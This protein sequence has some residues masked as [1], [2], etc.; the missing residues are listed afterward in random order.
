MKPYIPIA[1]LT[2]LCQFSFAQARP[3]DGF[4][5]LFNG[6][7]LTGWKIPAGD[8][9]HWKVLDGVID[10][11][12]GSEAKGDKNLW[13][14]KSY[15]DFILR[16]D[17]RIKQTTGMYAM[18]DV[19]PDGTYRKDAKGK[20]IKTL[21]PNADSGIYLRGNSRS[22]VNIWCWPIGSGEVYG[23]R[24]DKSMPAAVRAGVTPKTNADRDIG[25]WNTFVITVK[26]DRVWVKLN[27][28]Q[29]LE[30]A[31]LPG[32]PETGPIAL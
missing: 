4:V 5:S 2:L 11:D 8:N 29:V 9:G 13:T 22:Q 12:A 21:R 14:A 28:K 17:W 31:Q 23:Y 32:L 7:D 10:Y 20:V 19:L 27:G 30:N 16:I 3:D 6:K 26:G 18:P 24:N 25:E 15:K 1:A